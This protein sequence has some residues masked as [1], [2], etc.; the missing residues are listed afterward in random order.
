[1]KFID[2]YREAGRAQEWAEAIDAITTHP[3]TLME[4]CGGQTHAIV[5]YGLDTLLPPEI[6]LIHGPGLV[7]VH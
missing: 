1:M 7:P 6:R 5:K 3:W 2:E 4:V